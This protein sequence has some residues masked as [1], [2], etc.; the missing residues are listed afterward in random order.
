M[1]AFQTQQIKAQRPR[2]AYIIHEEENDSS[3]SVSARHR[4]TTLEENENKKDWKQLASE[5]DSA[6]QEATVS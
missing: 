1:H 3:G 4:P 5:I 6:Q 2:L